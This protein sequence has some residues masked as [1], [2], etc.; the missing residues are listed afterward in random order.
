MHS[1]APVLRPPAPVPQQRPLG[2]FALLKTLRRNA[3][4]CWTKAHFEEPIVLG[5]FPFAKV[6]VVSDPAAVRRILVEDQAS[7]HKSTL[8]R[9]ILSARLRN[10]LVA[11][12]GGEQWQRLRRTI[13]PMFAR[14]TIAAYAPAMVEVIAAM[15]RRWH[16]GPDG[17]IVVIKTEMLRL[18]LDSLLRCIFADGLGDPEAVADATVR[19]YSVCGTMDPFD[20]LGFPDFIPRLTRLRE[21]P[22]MQAFDQGLDEAMRERRRHL[23]TDPQAPRD[24]LGAMLAA[25]DPETG[26]S[27]T[28]A[29]VK[30][31]VMTFIFGGQ[32][33]TSSAL[34]WALY[35]LSQSDEWRERVTAEADHAAEAPPEAAIEALVQ[36]RAVI[37]EALRLY[38]PIIAITRNA[39]RRTE[40]LGHAIER[41]TLVVMP[42]YVIHRH[43]LLWRDPDQFDP[44]RFLP[45]ASE[46]I[47]RYA[48]LPFGVGPRMC[49]GA[50]FAMQEAVLAVA[51]IMRQFELELA[52]GENVWPVQKNF[53]MRPRDGLRMMAKRRTTSRVGLPRQ[54]T[55]APG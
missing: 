35:L 33:T 7:Y 19:Y 25:S 6:A 48:Y 34:T 16:D 13:A 31:N 5:G 23:A 39:A 50:G 26:Q 53:T 49:V 20:V 52:P 12:D 18:A 42:P 40:I 38:P 55:A 24:M 8:E 44:R 17:S 29:E 2:P 32:E 45:G 41:G 37:E 27:M 10:G 15:L 11:V 51:A 21:R 54:A 43:R 46:K 3:L 1:S 30:D 36:T 14:R 47:Q 22:I 9:R 4:E 28:E